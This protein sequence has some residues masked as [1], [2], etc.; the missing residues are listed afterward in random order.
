MDPALAG[1]PPAGRPC[2]TRTRVHAAAVR[3]AL[4]RRC[5]PRPP[6]SPP[7]GR[8]GRAARHAARGRERARC[9]RRD[10]DRGRRQ[11]DAGG[12]V[13][14]AG[15]V[16]LPRRPALREPARLRPVRARRREPGTA[17]QGFFDALGV[18]PRQVP[19][20]LEAQTALFRSLLEGRR[21]LLLLDNAH[22]TEQVRPLLPGQ[23]GLHGGGHQPYQLTG[24]VAAEGARPLPLDVLSD[25]EATELLAGRL[26]AERVAAEPD[27][28]AE[29]VGHCAGLPLA[30]S[31]TC[32]R[33]VTRPGVTLA[34]LAAELRGRARPARRAGDRRRGHRL[35]GRLLLVLSTS[36]AR[37]GPDVPAAR[38]APGARHLRRRG[39]LASPGCR[40][41]EARAALAEL[42]RA[43]L[44]TED[45]AGRFGCHDLLRAYAAEQAAD[46]ERA[47]EREAARR[48]L[49]RPLRADRARRERA[50]CTR[51]AG[52]SSCRPGRRTSPRRSSPPTRR[53]SP[54]STPSTASCRT[55]SAWPPRRASR[56]TTAGRSPGTGHRS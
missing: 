5:L 4:R 53:R 18:P 34:D 49:A 39:G 3:A 43:S 46:G 36:S 56:T 23:P 6:A 11:D 13:R 31:V 52:T 24:L 33:A 38:P 20:T 2:R 29:L 47:A 8:A 44:L 28:A 41:A 7:D 54:G 55:S 22:S 14:P 19:A 17:L 25:A 9:R 27:A 26:G 15:G 1:Q 12:P 45:A 21:M 35:A 16:A 50:D 40:P 10:R 42:T 37:G 48:R 30:L 32:A 51:R